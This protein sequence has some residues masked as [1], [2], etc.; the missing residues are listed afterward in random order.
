MY[1]WEPLRPEQPIL[2]VSLPMN[3]AFSP[4]RSVSSSNPPTANPWCALNNASHSYLFHS[5]QH[6][7][8]SGANSRNSTCAPA[9]LMSRRARRE[10][11]VGKWWLAGSRGL[12][13]HAPRE[14][15]WPERKGGSLFQERGMFRELL[16]SHFLTRLLAWGIAERRVVIRISSGISRERGGCIKQLRTPS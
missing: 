12:V 9:W 5:S 7:T 14:Q 11:R 13:N 10:K 8:R 2:S 16:I 1:H 15:A 6:S 4:S 3:S